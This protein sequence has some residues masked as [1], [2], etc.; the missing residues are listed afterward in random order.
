MFLTTKLET[1]HGKTEAHLTIPD[2]TISI[3]FPTCI[4]T[5]IPDKNGYVPP[6]TCNSLFAYY[7]SFAAAFVTT[8]VFGVLV[9]VHVFLAWKWKANYSWVVIMGAIWETLAFLFRAVSTKN[10]Q[11]S[12]LHLVGT[13]FLLLSPL[14]INAFCYIALARLIQT[15]HPQHSVLRIKAHHLS[16]L[17]V[18]LDFI[19][20]VIQ[21][22]GG[23]YASPTDTPEKILRGVHIYMG[24]I[25]I[26]Q[27]FVVVFVGLAFRFQMEMNQ[28]DRNVV[29][30]QKGKWKRLLWAIYGSLAFITIRIIFRLVQFTAGTKGAGNDLVGKE[31]YLYVLEAVPMIFAIACFV[32][33]HPGPI[34]DKQMP[35]IFSSLRR[36]L[37]WGRKTDRRQSTRGK[38]PE[39]T[40]VE[41]ESH[42]MKNSMGLRG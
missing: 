14:L 19:A 22:A 21:I 34:V 2:K 7:P 15:F 10:Q 20:F 32:V 9:G 17:F 40:Y 26:Q 41:L 27:F 6:G 39:G 16:I 28:I 3:I 30:E 12:G 4:Q 13:L 42:S 37:P 36:K 1:I 38:E 23:L 33:V 24:G 8:G 18:C 25:G 35:G 29:V 31:A 5:E 11:S